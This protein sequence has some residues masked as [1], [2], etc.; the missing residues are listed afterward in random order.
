MLQETI[1]DSVK[2]IESLLSIETQIEQAIE[3]IATSVKNG[4]TIFACGNG[5]SAAD[6]D[7]F[8][9]EFL[10]RLKNDRPPIPAVSLTTDGSFLT[11]TANDYH[12]DQVFRRQIEGLAKPGDVVVAISTSGNSPNV[13][14]ALE[15]CKEKGLSSVSFLGKDGGTC[16]GIATVDL[17]VPNQDTARIQEAHKVLIHLL[18]SGVEKKVY[19]ELDL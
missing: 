18:C 12:Y 13:L 10:C 16:K 2:A 5:G 8:T 4:G 15:A 1:Q 7:H 6:S 17:I 11:A 9:T 14:Q 3:T 19:P